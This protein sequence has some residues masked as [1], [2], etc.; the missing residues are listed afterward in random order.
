M[1]SM[2]ESTLCAYIPSF[3][4]VLGTCNTVTITI[5]SRKI[6]KL[7]TTM[8]INKLIIYCNS[9]ICNFELY[10]YMYKSLI[11]NQRNIFDLIHG[12][13]VIFSDDDFTTTAH[14]EAAYLAWIR[15]LC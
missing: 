5:K 14:S 9:V 11:L 10:Q 7:Q 15:A 12:M 1:K 4:R 8:F 13:T 3:C 2:L 6:A